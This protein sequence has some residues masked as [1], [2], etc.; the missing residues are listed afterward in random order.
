MKHLDYLV[1]RFSASFPN[2]ACEEGIKYRVLPNERSELCVEF[3]DGRAAIYDS[4][5]DGCVFYKS[6][7]AME[8]AARP[9]NKDIWKKQIGQKL[10]KYSLI[11]RK[12]EKDISELSGVSQ[13]T[14]SR[15]FNGSSDISLWNFV[16]IARAL[17]MNDSE[18]WKVLGI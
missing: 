8:S 12:S 18:V 9:E 10:Y 15:I 14:I 17:D 5:F 7:E 1:S 4:I 11:K 6:V 13:S 3:P 16:K 2:V